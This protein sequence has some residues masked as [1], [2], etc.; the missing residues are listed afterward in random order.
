MLSLETKAMEMGPSPCMA[1]VRREG[2]RGQVLISNP[3]KDTGQVHVMAAPWKVF[4]E[5]RGN[6]PRCARRNQGVVFF[7]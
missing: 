5:V 4:S 1:Q 3:G 6:S 7:K 2:R